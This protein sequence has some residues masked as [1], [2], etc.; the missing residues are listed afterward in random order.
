MPVSPVAVATPQR[1][2]PCV[3][4]FRPPTSNGIA[5]PYYGMACDQ[6]VSI[7]RILDSYSSTFT[8]PKVLRG[9]LPK[10]TPTVKNVT[11]QQ[12]ESVVTSPSSPT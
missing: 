3:V 7:S 9:S 11:G 1:L 8:Q 10:L 2:W 5:M 6:V 12:P 4:D